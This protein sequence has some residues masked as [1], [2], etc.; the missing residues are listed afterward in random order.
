VAVISPVASSPAVAERDRRGHQRDVRDQVVADDE[1]RA[2]ALQQPERERH[3]EHA[4]RGEHGRAQEAGLGRGEQRGGQRHGHAHRWISRRVVGAQ[5]DRADQQHRPREVPA[6]EHQRAEPG[7]PGVGD[8]VRRVLAALTRGDHGGQHGR[9][10]QAEQ[11]VRQPRP[12]PRQRRTIS[13][14]G[15]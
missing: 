3:R 1:R 2:L 8:Q 14:G 11:H 4:D 6:G 15:T 5:P 12:H 7:G 9:H 10:R 13:A